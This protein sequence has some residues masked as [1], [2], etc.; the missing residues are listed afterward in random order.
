MSNLSPDQ[1]PY[2]VVT[3]HGEKGRAKVRG[4]YAYDEDAE[5]AGRKIAETDGSILPNA[6]EPKDHPRHGEYSRSIFV[7]SNRMAAVYLK[8]E[9]RYR[10]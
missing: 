4:R 10:E 3:H 2:T 1:F 5:E 6:F 7:G 9:S 8:G